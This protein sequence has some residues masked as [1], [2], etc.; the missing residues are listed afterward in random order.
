MKGNQLMRKPK[1][2]RALLILLFVAAPIQ[3]T[4][5]QI[6]LSTPKTTLG[7]VIKNIKS[8]SNY[9]FFYDDKLAEMPV[10][11]IDVKNGS[12]Q[13]VLDAALQGKGITYKIEDNIVYLSASGEPQT[14]QQTGQEH[15]VTGTVVDA[16]GEALIGVN[17]QVKGNPTA[18]T[19]T[20]FEGNYSVRSR[21]W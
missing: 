16:T 19:I 15:T 8:Q 4:R 11:A 3:W 21:K 14:P 10:N 6:V 13:S 12:L 1:L 2:L 9:Q 5:A 7:A 20:D 18:G 17:V